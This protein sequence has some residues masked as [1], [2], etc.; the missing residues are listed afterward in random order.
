MWRYWAQTPAQGQ[1]TCE[2]RKSKHHRMMLPVL[3]SLG[4]R[5]SGVD[6]PGRCTP[7]PSSSATA[8]AS[9]KHQVFPLTP[10][11]MWMLLLL[12]V[13]DTAG[14]LM[15][16]RKCCRHLLRSRA[17]DPLE[18]P[19]CPLVVVESGGGGETSLMFRNILVMRL[20]SGRWRVILVVPEARSQ[21]AV[22]P[23]ST[24]GPAL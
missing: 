11:S 18:R 13:G 12:S 22:A 2:P 14:S 10:G 20:L 5:R 6:P 21:K 3:L 9:E 7:R 23:D 8:G 24:T 19:G 1:L 4:L 15:V 16:A 17:R